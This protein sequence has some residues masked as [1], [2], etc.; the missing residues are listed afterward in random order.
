MPGSFGE[1]EAKGAEF[2]LTRAI[3]LN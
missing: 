2:A 1:F 3:R